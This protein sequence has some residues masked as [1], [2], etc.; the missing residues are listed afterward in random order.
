M[1]D[2]SPAEMSVAET[3]N[4]TPAVIA[5]NRQPGTA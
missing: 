2:A 3:P 4:E 5:P 1:A